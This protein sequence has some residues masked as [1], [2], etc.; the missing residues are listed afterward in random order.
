MRAVLINHCHPSTPHVC[1]TRMREFAHALAQRGHQIVLLTETLAG[2]DE[3]V[4]VEATAGA[5]RGHDFTS[6]YI[7]ACPPNHIA[8]L[9]G[10]RNGRLPWGLSQA[11]VL[12]YYMIKGGVFAD[13]RSGCAPYLPALQT[14]FAPDIVWATFGN[15]DCWNLAKDMATIAKCPWVGDIKDYWSTFIPGPLRSILA[16]RHAAASFTALSASHAKDARTWFP[17]AAV[18]HSGFRREAL[19][20]PQG[21]TDPFTVSL[22]GGAYEPKNLA[23]LI[24]AVSTWVKS[25]QH[26][27]RFIYAGG[28]GDK[29]AKAT[30]GLSELCDVQ[31]NGFLPIAELAAIHRTS[32][33]N[34]YV[35]SEQ[36]FHH[37]I[38]ELIA[39][40]RPMISFPADAGEAQD[41]AKETA[42]AFYAC[43][44]G[45]EIIA[46]LTEIAANPGVQPDNRDKIA[47]FSWET[48]S[49][50]LEDLLQTAIAGHRQ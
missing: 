37:K 19:R 31:I 17:N 1:A 3:F 4:S 13:W 28:D 29:V 5:I 23:V 49:A 20:P 34:L 12:Y 45:G 24:D 15:T 42:A 18:V 43:G 9:D 36:T 50:R 25:R 8:A 41:I 11:V 48:Q 35:K 47:D 44:S 38:F 32:L 22:T 27:I 16:G 30:G 21:P 14:S 40:G 6:P 10:L 26:S 2:S 7:L 33:V 46:A 39:A